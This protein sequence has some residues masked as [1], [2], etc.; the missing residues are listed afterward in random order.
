MGETTRIHRRDFLRLAG[1]GLGAV[2]LRGS[3]RPPFQGFPSGDRLCR[4]TEVKVDLHSAPRPGSPV[5]STRGFDDVLV[6][7]REVVGEG[8]YPHNHV[9]FETPEGYLWSSEAQ[10]VRNVPNPLET[11]IPA[12]GIWTE[13][14]IPYTE[15]RVRPDASAPARYRLYYSMVLNVNERVAGDDG[16]TWYRVE[17]ENGVVMFAP[18][19]SFRVI[20]PDEIAPIGTGLE[21]KE[22]L[23]NLERQDLSAIEDGVEV[24]YCRISSG[25]AFDKEGKRVWNTPIG[26][27]WTWRKMVSR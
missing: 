1:A 8:V 14:S 9:W 15:G 10:P 17:D 27:N 22:I 4:I 24:Y 12:E 20:T 16:G 25:Y 6:L 11:T 3:L 21:E 7:L 18:G 19:E 5:V 13:L 26:Q 2:A 23:V